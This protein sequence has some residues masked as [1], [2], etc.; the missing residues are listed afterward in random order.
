MSTPNTPTTARF[1]G[2]ATQAQSDNTDA[3]DSLATVVTG[4]DV[5][6]PEPFWDIADASDI[7]L[8]WDKLFPFQFLYL[9]KSGNSYKI[10]DRFTLPIPPQSMS[11]ST[12][13]AINMSV[14]QGGILEEHNGAPLRTI[15]L[16]GTTGVLP[17]RGAVAKPSIFESQVATIFAG[18]VTGIRQVGT[19][20]SQA[21]NLLG[22]GSVPP[23]VVSDAELDTDSKLKGTGF[24]QFQL[25]KRFL[26]AYVAA[27]RAGDKDL[28]LGFAVWKEKEVYLV[29][30][31]SFD[32]SRTGANPLSYPF[33]ITMRAW[34]RVLLDDTTGAQDPYEGHVGARDPNKL[35]QVVNLLE[36]GR[37]VLEGV[38]YTLQG[39]RADI[40]QV[41]FTPLR[42]TLLLA[43]DATGVVL[44]AVDLP[45]DI[46]SDLKEPLLEAAALPGS[47][48]A[49]LGRVGQRFNANL[50][51]SLN[52][53]ATVE[54]AFKELSISSGKADTGAGR[55]GLQNA[56]GAAPANKISASPA[57]NFEFFASIRP[58]DLNLRPD[59]IRKIESERRKVKLLGRKDFE[60]FRDETLRVLSDF[61]DFVGAGNVTFT[62]TY[63][64]P[65][66]A[67]SRTPT[68]L[69]WDAMYALSQIAQQYDTLAASAQIDRNQITSMDYVA[70]LATRA[71]IAF[72]VARSKFAV[73]FPYSYTLEKLSAKY[74][75]SPDRWLEIAT[76]NGLRAP[77]V[78]ETGFRLSLLTNGNGSQILVSSADSLYVGQQVWIS[79]TSVRRESRRIQAIKQLGTGQY[80]LN[81]S[82]EADLDKYTTVGSAFLEAFLP[83]TV[84][85]QQ[86]IYIPSDVEPAEEDFL[87]R[88]IPGIDYFDP[89]VKSG[90]ID[91]LLT[92][93]GDLVIT[94]D[95][96]GRLA[97]GLTNLIQK[98]RLAI[99]TPRGSLLHHPEYGIGLTPGI[100]TADLTASQVLTDLQQ[101]F[102]NDSGYLG[103]QSAGV[104]K[105]GNSLT[106][107]ASIGIA[108]TGQYIP[109]AVEIK[110]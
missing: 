87:V 15:S 69:E 18:T 58:S 86:Q 41:L 50:N 77:Y 55:S 109:V 100:S 44:A 9:R 59:T 19:A 24:Y 11:I 106:V 54:A 49:S 103:V 2:A 70:G 78:D 80:A 53:L 48:S 13:F 46:I 7:G 8:N 40:Q 81:L 68:D 61:S 25:L 104:V 32:V 71:G 10:E 20:I 93:D 97:V 90:G 16:Q 92:T 45:T 63:G 98:A 36:S 85:S 110:R 88:S 39:I 34:R 56:D 29:T 31:V 5:K 14:T 76:L 4:K 94:P 82:G 96:D 21:R 38:R 64:L 66:R 102:R 73:P 35:A 89:M 22:V 33:N 51:Q 3:F 72:Q 62:D 17:L 91:L 74:L 107:R 30:P 27:K 47:V 60:G 108:G 57:Q 101:L 105:S 43:K 67:S 1:F 65:Q 52:G 23:N 6:S 12:P 37:R 26:E 75:G 84:N 99:G 83:G 28:K 79:S 95:G 42:Q